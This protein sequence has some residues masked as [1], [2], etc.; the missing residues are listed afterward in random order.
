MLARTEIDFAVQ[1]VRTS[2]LKVKSM[3]ASNG[4]NPVSEVRTR[5]NPTPAFEDRKDIGSLHEWQR[6][7]GL[8]L[9]Q[10]RIDLA[11]A[12][13]SPDAIPAH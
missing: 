12:L 7:S 9:L 6:Q 2:G 11:A 5:N 13:G 4:R 1:L 3:H 10:N 8:E